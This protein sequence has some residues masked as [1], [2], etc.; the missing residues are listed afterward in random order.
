MGDYSAL[1]IEQARGAR[2][3][4]WDYLLHHY[5]YLGRPNLVGELRSMARGERAP[6]LA[7]GDG[8]NLPGKPLLEGSHDHYWQ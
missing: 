3:D 1:V 6:E 8:S 2:S 5:H 4:L 7:D